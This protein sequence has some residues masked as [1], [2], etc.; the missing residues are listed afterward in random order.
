M[1]EKITSDLEKSEKA[2]W[3]KHHLKQAIK[4][5]DFFF[6]FQGKERHFRKNQK[7]RGRNIQEFAGIGSGQL[8][9]KD[10]MG[11]NSAI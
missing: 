2:S 1:M 9:W 6:F 10:R 4:I 7:L 8:R 11:K 5:E 3:K